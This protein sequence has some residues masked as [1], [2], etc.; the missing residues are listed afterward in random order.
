MRMGELIK[1]LLSYFLDHKFKLS[2]RLR[3]NVWLSKLTAI[4]LK[5]NE[6]CLPLQRKETN[7]YRAQNN[8]IY[9]SRRLQYWTSEVEHNVSVFLLNFYKN[10]KQNKT[11]TIVDI[12][13]HLAGL[14]ESLTMY[15]HNFEH[16]EHCW[17]QNPF[18]VVEK[19]PGFQTADYEKLIEI[20]SDTQLKANFEE[21]SLDVF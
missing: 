19:P 5:L 12:K 8:M 10:L 7:I 18:C 3:N 17:E 15:F 20:T 14:S 6:A 13:D 1:E 2:D 9:F 16:N 4:F 21:V 11:Q